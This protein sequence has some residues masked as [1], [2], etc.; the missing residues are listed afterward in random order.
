MNGVEA[1]YQCAAYGIDQALKNID[2]Y[3]RKDISLLV[4]SNKGWFG[5]TLKVQDVIT[6]KNNNVFESKAIKDKANI[7]KIFD[8]RVQMLKKHLSDDEANYEN[9]VH[10]VGELSVMHE[11]S[12][13]YR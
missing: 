11:V 7:K 13:I 8:E 2:I 9:E 1:I 6:I 12:V 5:G 3:N 4:C 10:V